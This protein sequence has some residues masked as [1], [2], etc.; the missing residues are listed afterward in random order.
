M[1]DTAAPENGQAS[2]PAACHEGLRERKK[3]ESREAMHLAALE[4]VAEHGLAHV[5]VEQIAERAGVSQRTLF[6]YWGTKEAVV[7]GVEPES[8]RHLVEAFRERP[9]GESVA[10]SMRVLIAAHVEDA[11]PR[12]ATRELKRRVLTS[13]PQLVQMIANR[14]NDVRRELIDAATERLT[15]TLGPEDARDA[16]TIHVSW[17]FALIRSVYSIASARDIDLTE[18]LSRLYSLLESGRITL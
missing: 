6:N 15:R 16:A 2:G 14:N 8:A 10:D 13:E 7:L 9:R 11:G 3:R 18:A 12:L 5:T 4:L 17:A 1:S